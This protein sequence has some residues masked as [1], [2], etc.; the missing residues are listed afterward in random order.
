MVPLPALVSSGTR[1]NLYVA[2]TPNELVLIR[3]CMLPTSFQSSA[4]VMKKLLVPVILQT[5]KFYLNNHV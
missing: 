3:Y 5:F 4:I 1:L 2:Q